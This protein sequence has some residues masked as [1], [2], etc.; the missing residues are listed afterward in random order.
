MGDDNVSPRVLKSCA[1][2]LS[3]PLTAF[4]RKICYD[5]SF[6]NSWKISR[7]TPVYKKGAL[8]DPSNYKPIAVLPTLSRVFELRIADFPATTPGLP[9]YPVRSV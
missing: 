2:A 3:G 5:A 4:F 8:S 6:P 9:S 1:F 7:I